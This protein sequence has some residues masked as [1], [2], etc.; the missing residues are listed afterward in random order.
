MSNNTTDTGTRRSAIAI[1]KDGSKLKAVKLR[2]QGALFEVL[3]TKSSE[4]GDLDWKAF[5][6]ECGLAAE[7]T[8]QEKSDDGKMVVAG[9]DSAGVVFYRVD[10]PTVSE[11]EIAA[12]VKLQAEARMPLP[13]EQIQLAWRAEQVQNG[14]VPVTIAAA[15]KERLQKFVENVRGFGPEQILLDCEAIV[16]TWRTF[17]S[18]DGRNAVVVSMTTQNTQVCLAQNGQ[19]TNAVVL[20]TGTEDLSQT[21]QDLSV[22]GA[23]ML[24]DQTETT[25]RFI[26]DIRS[27]LEL[28]G[29]AGQAGLPVFVLSDDSAAHEVVVSSLKSAGLNV[30]AA[31][32]QIEKLDTRT[33]LHPADIYEYRVPIGLALTAIDGD[34]DRLNIFEQLYCSPGEAKS[35]HRLNSTKAAFVVTA[36]MLVLLVIVAYA[37][38]VASPGA[39]EKR[40][41]GTGDGSV[42]QQLN[43][44]QKLIKSVASQ[45]P[46]LLEL[47]HQI[48]TSF[49][50]STKLDYQSDL[51][52]G[53]L[54]EEL[55]KKFEENKSPLSQRANVSVE[56]A[57]TRWL[58]T[59]RSKK[60]SIR[61]EGSRLKIYDTTA[62]A[63]I[64]LDKLDFKKGRPI[65]ITAQ[66]KDAEQMYKFE[67][68]LLTIKGITG[69][70]IQ[71]SA[72]DNKTKKLKFTM[73][74][75]YR[76]FTGK[77]TRR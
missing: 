14:K 40:L 4:A 56:Q 39:I 3:W 45:R 7:L 57:G 66:T 10:L 51:D 35:K 34:T 1:A 47:L 48:H 73:T 64:T 32:P 69:V 36:V 24:T 18:G 68:S 63:G 53:T 55:L 12:M 11:E 26:Q 30:R 9:F 8:E 29:Y 6:L 19:L 38:D 21:T 16:K 67:K 74:F 77:R 46:D 71:N 23:G 58:I 43:D 65:S 42:V 75:Y 59:N 54:S 15:R 62:N 61:K 20:D 17:F 27:V 25:E 22:P 31:Y 60:Y 50:F 44:R 70:K 2:K 5:E 33:K 41:D 49:L 13:S 76:D 28:F 52:K 72:R 37:V